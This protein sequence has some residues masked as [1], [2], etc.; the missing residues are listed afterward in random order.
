MEERQTDTRSDTTESA[1]A[2]AAVRLHPA[3]DSEIPCHQE[4]ATSGS[5]HR[6]KTLGKRVGNSPYPN[7]AI[8]FPRGTREGLGRRIWPPHLYQCIVR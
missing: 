5:S 4:S 1:T 8:H 2:A 7:T 3:A 6:R